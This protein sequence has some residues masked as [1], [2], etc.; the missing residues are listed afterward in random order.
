M[1]NQTMLDF[2]LMV[3]QLFSFLSTATSY[4]NKIPDGL[5]LKMIHRDFQNSPIYQANLT[6]KERMENYIKM[7]KMR[8]KSLLGPQL[9]RNNK[10]L[11][12]LNRNNVIIRPTLSTQSHLYLI[13]VGI[14]TFEDESPSSRTYYLGFDTASDVTWTQCEGCGDNCF[15]QVDPLFPATRSSTYWQFPQSHCPESSKW[16]NNRC[17]LEM[18][19]AD[20]ATVLAIVAKEVFTFAS[21]DSRSQ[22][23]RLIFGCGFDMQNFPKGNN[24]DNKISGMMGMGNGF[25]SFMTQTHTIFNGNFSYCIQPM[26]GRR[27]DSPMYLRF[28]NDVLPQ[29]IAG[30]ETTPIDRDRRRLSYYLNLQGISVD[31]KRLDIPSDFLEIARD[32]ISAGCVI[33][34]GSSISTIANRAFKIF[35]NAVRNFILKKNKNVRQMKKPEMGYHLCFERYRN[36]LTLNLPKIT[37]H[38]EGNADFVIDINESFYIGVTRNQKGMVCM[39]FLNNTSNKYGGVTVLGIHQQANKRIIYDLSNNLLHFASTDCSRDN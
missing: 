26:F 4:A 19:Y 32:G 14:G 36:P 11:K 8:V 12:S 33:D 23:I 20:G 9:P 39:Q 3:L 25:Y 29:Q 34:S 18:R 28:G 27:R 1:V 10:S 15:N 16:K 2:V 37:F 30:M 35:R 13:Q 6:D 31:T 5:T 17:E 21:E 38:F 22:G 7:S 24:P